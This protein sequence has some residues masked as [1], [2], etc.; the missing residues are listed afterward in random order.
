V[1][2]AHALAAVAFLLFVAA[3][4]IIYCV[5]KPRTRWLIERVFW[6]LFGVLFGVTML[7]AILS[8]YGVR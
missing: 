4:V 3:S 6:V 1:Q 2:Y 7:L 8:V 5:T